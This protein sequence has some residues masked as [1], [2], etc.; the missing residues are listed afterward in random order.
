M[1]GHRS[2]R[3]AFDIRV[4]FVSFEDDAVLL[5]SV[6]RLHRYLDAHDGYDLAPLGGCS[7]DFWAC[8]HAV[9]VSVATVWKLWRRILRRDAP[10]EAHLLQWSASWVDCTKLEAQ[11]DIKA[12]P[13]LCNVRGIQKLRCSDWRHLKTVPNER[14][15]LK[16]ENRSRANLRFYG[17]GYFAQDRWD[18]RHGVGEA[19]G[20]VRL[21][22]FGNRCKPGLR[23]G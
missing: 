7:K 13:Q 3:Y 22:S 8:G 23:A 19:D 6:N 17:Y 20:T 9:M 11:L 4:P 10:Q 21:C 14:F 16:R 18:A 15:P 2:G 12:Y 1:A 5:T